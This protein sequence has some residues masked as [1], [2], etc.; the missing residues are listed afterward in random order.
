MEHNSLVGFPENLTEITYSDL[1][2]DEKGQYIVLYIETSDD[3]NGCF[4]N[5]SFRIPEG[6]PI[7]INGYEE[8]KLKMVQDYVERY[9]KLALKFAK[10]EAG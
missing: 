10:E 8:E 7:V 3:E 1:K 5:A 4:C 2:A 6:T 9:G